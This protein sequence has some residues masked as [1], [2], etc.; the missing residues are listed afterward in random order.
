MRP[1]GG[2]KSRGTRTARAAGG[3][4]VA[5]FCPCRGLGCP[6]RFLKNRRHAA[7]FSW[8]WIFWVNAPVGILAILLAYFLFPPMPA[9]TVP[10]LD[11]LG[12]IL[13]G[14]GLATLTYSLSAFSESTL[15]HSYTASMFLLSLVLLAL[16]YWHSQKQAYPIVKVFLLNKRTF[17]ISVLG[18]LW[19]LRVFAL[20]CI[21]SC[22]AR[23][24]S[25]KPCSI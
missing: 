11:I 6:G 1:E 23:G 13:F 15:S 18:N 16:Y 7:H 4:L 3:I 22:H 14:A 12:F 20:N 19:A 2:S 9:L 8:P 21:F 5:C 10:P 25:K 24:E 17:R